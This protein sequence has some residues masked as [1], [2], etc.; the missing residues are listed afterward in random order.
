LNA[1]DSTHLK[2]NPHISLEGSMA[3]V[4]LTSLGIYGYR[5]QNKMAAMPHFSKSFN[6][7][8]YMYTVFKYTHL[9]PHISDQSPY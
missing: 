1:C 7:T 8:R 6:H 2:R 4:L 3:A 5:L 9:P